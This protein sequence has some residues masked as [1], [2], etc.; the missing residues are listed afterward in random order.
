MDRHELN[1]MFDA[2]APG[3]GRERELLEQLLQD[4][5]R[6]N[7]PMKNWKRV[8]VGVAAAAL[9]VTVAAAAVPGIST[10]LWRLIGIEPEDTQ[11]AELLASGITP[12]DV[13]VESSGA[14]LHITQLLRDQ[15]KI[16]L[17]GDFSTAEGTI[18]DTGDFG[19]SCEKPKGFRMEGLPVFLDADG[20]P[21]K[22]D[23][24][25]P[26]DAFWW[27]MPDDDP[28]DNHCSVYFVYTGYSEDMTDDIAAIRVEAKNFAYYIG[29]EHENYTT[30][31]GDWSF[32]VPLPRQDPG[33]AWKTDK[34]IT[35]LDGADINLRKVYLSPMELE[36]TCFREGGD[37]YYGEA[38]N[39]IVSRWW[40]FPL[41]AVLTT[42]GGKS[43]TLDWGGGGGGVGD[44]GVVTRFIIADFVGQDKRG[45]YINPA[46]FQGG[47]LTLEWEAE[48]GET[49]SAT[50]PLDDLTP[51]AP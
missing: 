7:R 26:R 48:T 35:N 23:F 2:L 29:G 13:T 36:L 5:A 34:L 18:L 16:V 46:D 22:V 19:A 9:L 1:K 44:G 12:V 14:T 21:V 42:K 30:I 8:V 37:L 47:T 41:R 39:D 49:D 17:V 45:D 4:D 6:R 11:S 31:P 28:L 40:C 43:V 24:K 25:G 32:E 27:S 15:V 20:E 10:P 50:F 51:A 38:E 3:P 33:Y